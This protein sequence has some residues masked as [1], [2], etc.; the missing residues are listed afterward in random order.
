MKVGVAAPAEPPASFATTQ[1]VAKAHH[2]QFQKPVPPIFPHMEQW[3]LVVI[4][5]DNSVVNM[6]TVMVAVRKY[7][8]VR[9]A[10]LS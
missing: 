2:R 6:D 8:Q 7:N 9:Q 3:N 1:C 4:A 10:Q 5:L